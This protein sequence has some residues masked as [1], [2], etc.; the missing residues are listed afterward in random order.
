MLPHHMVTRRSVLIGGVSVALVGCD[1]PNGAGGVD[2]GSP[3]PWPSLSPEAEMFLTMLTIAGPGGGILAGAL[4]L[5]G[6]RIA[7]RTAGRLA[8]YAG[9]ISD[10]IEVVNRVRSEL[11]APAAQASSPRPVIVPES[12]N[13]NDFEWVPVFRNDVT[14]QFGVMNEGG[15]FGDYDIYATVKRADEPV[16]RTLRD[17]FGSAD[18]PHAIV[19]PP[20]NGNYDGRLN[21][22]RLP[23]GA[24]VSYSWRVPRGQQPSDDYIASTVF[25]GPA[26]LSV[27]DADY[28]IDLA[29]AIEAGKNVEARFQLPGQT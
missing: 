10:L 16:P 8:S 19:S 13:I 18:L 4:R 9:T 5:G 15:N 26:F 22:G 2:G 20:P 3:N 27:E 25:I 6:M 21:I 14:L 23:S 17:V 28:S 11:F 7:L 29:D 12:G 24:F 1:Q